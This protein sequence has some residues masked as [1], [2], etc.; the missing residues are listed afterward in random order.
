MLNRLFFMYFYIH[1]YTHVCLYM[2]VNIHI[3]LQLIELQDDVT[4]KEAIDT[5]ER[6]V[7]KLLQEKKSVGMYRDKYTRLILEF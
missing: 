1:V 7:R 2:Y 5:Y 3:G 4:L 6:I